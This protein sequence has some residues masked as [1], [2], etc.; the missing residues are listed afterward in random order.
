MRFS[1]VLTITSVIVTSTIVL[2]I[3]VL[4]A[5]RS[6][7]ANSDS[8]ATSTRKAEQ[9]PD[10]QRDWSRVEI[11]HGVALY[12]PAVLLSDPLDLGGGYKRFRSPNIEILVDYGLTQQVTGCIVQNNQLQASAI[13]VEPI[14][15][16][17]KEARI[18]RVDKIAFNVDDDAK[19]AVKGVLICVPN[20][21]DNAHA[22]SVVGKYRSAEDYQ[23][24]SRIID[25]IRFSK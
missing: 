13:K 12:L 2:A 5:N 25:S 4:V 21:G 6:R 11:E 16:D 9:N 20:V 18:Q 8:K 7:R 10:A 23:T 1:R 15:V 17:G 14:S 19:L 22:F 3:G 24:L